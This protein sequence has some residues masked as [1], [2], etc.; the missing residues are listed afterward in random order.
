MNFTLNDKITSGAYQLLYKS[1]DTTSYSPKNKK[2]EVRSFHTNSFNKYLRKIQM[3]P[4]C[5]IALDTITNR[6][7]SKSDWP[8]SSLFKNQIAKNGH[9]FG[10]CVAYH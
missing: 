2:G 3:V 5:T 1:L 9:C 8:A 7:L 10:F 6:C 4:L